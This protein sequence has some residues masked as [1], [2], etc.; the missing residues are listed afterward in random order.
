MRGEDFAAG[1]LKASVLDH[2]GT[3][4]IDNPAR[5]NAVTARMWQA[6]P[7]A[8]CWLCNEA[9]ARVIIVKGAGDTDFSAGADISEFGTVRKDAE[10]ARIY[11]AENSKAFAALRTAPVPSI[12]AIRGICYG[13]GF[14]LAAACDIRIADEAARFCIPPAKLGLAYPADA[15][16]DIVEGLG[17]QA[18][19]YALY[20]GAVM[21]SAQLVKWGFL[22]DCLQPEALDAHVDRL[23]ATIA[24]NAPFSVKASRLAIRAV[25]EGNAEAGAEAIAIGASTFESADYAEGRKAF[26][27]KRKP[28]FTGR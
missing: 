20:T 19:R 8:V 2:V 18:A 27:E 16:A 1:L 5:K 13:G 10:T 28:Q 26:A 23:A 6:L 4:L 17:G 25:V 12:A 24:S 21:E 22:L 9:G 14:G 11:E 15:V 3:I 7:D